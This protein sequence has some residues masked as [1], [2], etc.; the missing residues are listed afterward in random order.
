MRLLVT[1]ASGFIGSHLCERLRAEG[2]TLWALVRD[3]RKAEAFGVPGTL[4][5]GELSTSRERPNAWVKS[6][7]DD[8]DAVI[9][10]AG[11]AHTFRD[12]EFDLVNCEASR[13]LVADL[14][15]RHPRLRWIQVSSLAA[16]GPGT[17]LRDEE[18]EASPVSRYGKSKLAAERALIEE[19]PADWE[20]AIVRPP[21]VIGPRDP[22]FLDLFKMTRN[23]LAVYPGVTGP[24]KRYSFVGVHDL[25]RV[26]E[27]CLTS[28]LP[29]RPATYFAAHPEPVRFSELL[30]AIRKSLGIRATLPLFVPAP[31]LSMVGM[32]GAM[33]S[34]L[35]LP[36]SRLT[37][38]KAREAR[39]VGW[40]C[41][42]RR[43]QDEL[44]MTYEWSLD[45][46]LDETLRDYRQR[47]WL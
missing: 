6:L 39:Q 34:S 7:P 35:G 29:R 26:L 10:L 28:P 2:H 12:A 43:S 23:R 16:A 15:P 3:A 32:T 21:I 37:P 22:G 44:G 42:P 11:L 4:V 13:R 1:G 17:T 5:V 47:G 33:I 14:T 24:W 20:L 45:A 46:I 36:A 25:V 40:L 41:S 9:H 18:Q 27:L 30:G 8:L 19:A 31:V 38:D